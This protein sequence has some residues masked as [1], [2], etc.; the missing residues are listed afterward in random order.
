MKAITP[1]FARDFAAGWIAAWNAHD[2][3]KVLEHY[4]EDVE[5]HSPYVVSIAGDSTG[6]ITGKAALRA[7]WSTALSKIPDL[8]FELI[9]VLLGVGSLTI[10]YKGHRGTVAEVLF[11]E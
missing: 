1:E 5:L 7:Y 8:R 6:R 3:E 11:F 4:S 2:L 10:Y 9:E